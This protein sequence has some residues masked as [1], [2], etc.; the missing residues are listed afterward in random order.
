MTRLS[1]VTN[2]KTNLS[3]GFRNWLYNG[4]LSVF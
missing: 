4:S 1:F 3:G 2:K